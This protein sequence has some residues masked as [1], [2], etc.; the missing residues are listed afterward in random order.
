MG[1]CCTVQLVGSTVVYSCG[2][3]T[4]IL[5]K[6][7]RLWTVCWANYNRLERA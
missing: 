3:W 1:V 4:E 5:F 6:S 2:V 7:R